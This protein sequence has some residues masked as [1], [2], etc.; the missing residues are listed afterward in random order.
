MQL[1]VK[2]VAGVL[3]VSEKTIYRWINSRVMP[4]YLVNSQYRFSRAQVMEWA[5]VRRIKVSRDIVREPESEEI[6]LPTLAEA[7]RAGGVAYRLGGSDKNSVLRAL[8]ETLPLAKEVDREF[9]FEVLLAREALASTGVGN[10]IAIPHVRNP[11]V[12]HLGRTTVT[13]CYLEKPVDYGAID[14]RPVRIIFS[15]ISPTLRG[16]LHLLS[17]L[18]FALRD[19]DF[20]AVL[21]REGSRDELQAEVRRIEATFARSKRPQGRGDAALADCCGPVGAA[22]GDIR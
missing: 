16:H 14:G 21:M 1:T 6:P 22:S 2:D 13:L 17:R 9:L 8:V 7:L 12:Q 3:G 18:A 15:P 11:V 4:A 5:A 10:G 20:K 19:A